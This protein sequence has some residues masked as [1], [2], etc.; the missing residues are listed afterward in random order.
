MPSSQVC[1][2][3]FS[4]PVTPV[5]M[6][7]RR[8][9]TRRGPISFGYMHVIVAVTA[10]TT[11]YAGPL[12]ASFFKRRNLSL[13]CVIACSQSHSSKRKGSS[14]SSHCEVLH[15][16]LHALPWGRVTFQL[17]TVLGLTQTS[18]LW[19]IPENGVLCGPWA[20]KG[21]PL[22]SFPILELH[23]R[24]GVQLDFRVMHWADGLVIRASWTSLPR[25]P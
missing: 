9:K 23:L 5:E 3:V 12:T 14:P 15:H 13:E 21:P 7:T 22:S 18:V 1:E 16:R 8:R 10:Q 4:L 6:G 2:C 25:A 17:I 24:L 11:L 20:N 19:N